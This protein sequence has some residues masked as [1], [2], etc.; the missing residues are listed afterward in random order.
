MSK[1]TGSGTAEQP[2]QLK[3]P[4]GTSEY[5]AYLDEEADP[6]ALVV[7]V[8]KT[9]AS[10]PPTLHRRPSRHAEEERRLG[11]AGERRR[12]EAGRAAALSRPGDVPPAIRSK[13]GTASRR[14]CVA[15]LGCT[16]PRCWRRWAWPRSST[17]PRT[18]G[19]GRRHQVDRLFAGVVG[20][21]AR[22]S[23]RCRRTR[24]CWSARTGDDPVRSNWAGRRFANARCHQR[25]C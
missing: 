9:R 3:T 16:S 14:D 2:W 6:P 22:L 4:P 21:P 20:P 17:I 23:E 18:T 10:L 25:A 5:Q 1:I 8:G 11:A 15:V 24:P 7:Q 13:G 12:A 19:C